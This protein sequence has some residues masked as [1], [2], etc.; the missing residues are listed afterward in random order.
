MH[1][2]LWTYRVPPSL[3]KDAI[4]K[5]F[6]DV[7]DKY[8]GIPGLVRKYFGFSEDGGSVIGVYLW[9]SREAAEAF[10]TPQWIADVTRRWGAAPVKSE[11]IV[12]VVTD[13]I[14]GRVVRD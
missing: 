10:Y 2:V 11:W 6:G 1:C 12:P 7:A 3:T 14:T 4:E 5:L 8:L 9:T 13:T